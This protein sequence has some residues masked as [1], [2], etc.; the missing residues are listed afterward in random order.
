MDESGPVNEV[1]LRLSFRSRYCPSTDHG[2]YVQPEDSGEPAD[3]WMTGL[4]AT[5]P[6][7]DLARLTPPRPPRL[8]SPSGGP[9][10]KPGCRPSANSWAPS[11]TCRGDGPAPAPHAAPGPDLTKHY[12]RC[13]LSFVPQGCRWV[14]GGGGRCRPPGFPAAGRGRGSGPG[15]PGLPDCC[16]PWR[17]RRPGRSARAGPPARRRPGKAPRQQQVPRRHRRRDYYALSSLSRRK[18]RAGQRSDPA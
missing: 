9:T 8:S 11:R 12:Q 6:V 17:I 1:P 14:P 10:R 3:H 18:W 15:V 7:A 4:P 2:V 16:R 13:P 5:A